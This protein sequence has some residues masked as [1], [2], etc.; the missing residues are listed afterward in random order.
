LQPAHNLF[1][2]HH[3][4]R[5]DEAMDIDFGVQ[6]SRIFD[7]VG[8]VQCVRTPAGEVART[9]HIGPYGRLGD[10]HDAIHTWCAAKNRK[11]ATASWEIYGHWNDNPALLETKIKYLLA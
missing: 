1:L 8:N 4:G 2:Y 11:I 5:P 7:S 9:I 6:V 3:P 10:A